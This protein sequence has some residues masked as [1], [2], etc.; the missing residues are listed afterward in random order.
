[1]ICRAKNTK[2]HV[3][4][5]KNHHNM[6]LRMGKQNSIFIRQLVVYAT[7]HNISQR[8]DSEHMNAGL[9][10]KLG[11]VVATRVADFA[12]SCCVALNGSLGI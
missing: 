3:L 1:M 6:I 4:D 12:T 2:Q 10:F 8:S 9:E 7:T 5:Q 11:Q